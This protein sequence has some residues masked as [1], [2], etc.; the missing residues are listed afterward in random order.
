MGNSRK[1]GVE[2]IL[3]SIYLFA[4]NRDLFF[5]KYA[6]LTVVC[7]LHNLI[8]SGLKSKNINKYDMYSGQRQ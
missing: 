5:G 2:D 6:C 1:K 7:P 3:F 4:T 8:M